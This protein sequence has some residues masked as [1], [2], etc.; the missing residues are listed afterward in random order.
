[1]A[2]YRA[3]LKR[4][5][6]AWVVFGLADI[7]FMIYSIANGQSYSSSFN[8]FAVIVGIFL[9]R[10]SLGATTLVTWFSAL[11]LAGF[12]GVILIFPFLQPL[13]LLVVQAKL[14]PVGSAVTWLMAIAVLVLLGWS[15]K[16]LRSPSVLEARKASGRTTAM[17]KIAFALGIAL[18]AFLGTMLGMTLNGATGAKAVEL[19]RQQLGSGYKYSTQSFSTGGGHTSAI[20]AAYNDN[21]I[22]YVPV[23]WSE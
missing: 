15:Y 19:A 16:Q 22:K 17:P 8:I 2:D 23:E 1:M 12:I 13:G 7:A 10:G 18:V 20:V 4:V 3:I 9:I 5:G 21:E 6:L 11:M 14:N